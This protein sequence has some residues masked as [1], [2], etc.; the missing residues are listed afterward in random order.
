MQQGTLF[1]IKYIWC[2]IVLE[3]ENYRVSDTL[4]KE[5]FYYTTIEYRKKKK[6]FNRN[7]T[8]NVEICYN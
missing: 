2:I 1:S 7:S 3:I 5:I 6:W 8:K 4:Y